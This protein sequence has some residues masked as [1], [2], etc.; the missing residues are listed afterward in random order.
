MYKKASLFHTI[1][2]FFKVVMVTNKI[3]QGFTWSETL[4]QIGFYYILDW[5]KI[6]Q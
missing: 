1:D 4:T 6:S 2:S 5:Q 3:N